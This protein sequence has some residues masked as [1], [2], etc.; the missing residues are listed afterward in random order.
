[1]NE[2]Y[3]D[4]YAFYGK[5]DEKKDDLN[6]FLKEVFGSEKE[7]RP[8]VIRNP[9]CIFTENVLDYLESEWMI[10][11]VDCPI[12]IQKKAIDFL[13]KLKARGENVQNTAA[14]IARKIKGA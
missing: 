3:D 6:E 4:F 2:N 10:V 11:L 14:K 5:K 7:D 9:G 13:D 8:A 1:M 12:S